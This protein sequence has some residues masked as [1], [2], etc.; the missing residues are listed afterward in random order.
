ML[1]S[2]EK[3]HVGVA[4]LFAEHVGGGD[5]AVLLGQ[6]PVFDTHRAPG[7]REGGDIPRGPQAIGSAHFGIDL[8]RLV[9]GQQHALDESGRGFHPGAQQHQWRLQPLTVGQ[10]HGF[11]LALALDPHDFG[12]AVEGDP[13]AFVQLA[14]AA[15]DALAQLLGQ[16]HFVAGDQVHLQAVLAQGRGGFQADETVADDHYRLAGFGRVKQVR[17]ILP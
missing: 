6:A 8:H 11:D 7:E 13:L 5:H 10:Q 2:P 14:D 4:A 12:G 17:G 16:R 1:V 15:A 3:R 9:F